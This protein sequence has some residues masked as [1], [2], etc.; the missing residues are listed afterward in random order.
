M[1]RD[2]LIVFTD[3][4]IKANSEALVATI[5]EKVV[6]KLKADKPADTSPP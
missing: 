1:T 5:V 6:E 2:E 3:E 4:R